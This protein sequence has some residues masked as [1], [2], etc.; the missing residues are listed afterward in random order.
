MFIFQIYMQSS[1]KIWLNLS[2][3]IFKLPDIYWPW[4]QQSVEKREKN[5][6]E[7]REKENELCNFSQ[8]DKCLAVSR[9]KTFTIQQFCA[10]CLI[11]YVK[12]QP[13]KF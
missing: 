4:L 9:H 10:G 3:Y 13:L 12:F 11:I 7:T 2:K 6:E 8:E 5:R 1:D